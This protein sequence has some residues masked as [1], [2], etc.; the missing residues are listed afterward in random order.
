V[1]LHD[2]GYNSLNTIIYQINTLRQGV[3]E[4]LLYLREPG[5]NI[6][7]YFDPDKALELP[8]LGDIEYS[9]NTDRPIPYSPLYNLSE[10]QLEVLYLYL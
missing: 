5:H 7:D 1:L 8:D 4:V 3:S 10:V 2:S 9:I 6:S